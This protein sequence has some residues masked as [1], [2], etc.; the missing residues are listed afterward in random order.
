MSLSIA[1]SGPRPACPLASTSNFISIGSAG[2][3]SGPCAGLT[4]PGAGSCAEPVLH[5][6]PTPSFR[7][8][9]SNPATGSGAPPARTTAAFDNPAER[10][11]RFLSS[12]KYVSARGAPVTNVEVS[13]S[14]KAPS[15]PGAASSSPAEV[16]K[17]AAPSLRHTCTC[18]LPSSSSLS[19]FLFGIVQVSETWSPVRVATRLFTGT[20]RLS[21]GGNGAPGIPQPLNT[22]PK[23]SPAP[24]LATPANRTIPCTLFIA[25]P[26][27]WTGVKGV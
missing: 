14:L 23:A 13:V 20:G 27:Y 6:T 17:L 11:L 5:R 22:S 24:A 15:A 21:E 7:T 3:A 25:L 9:A 12:T 4:A 19:V 2:G 26:V 16:H 18:T 8:S 1:R 10:S